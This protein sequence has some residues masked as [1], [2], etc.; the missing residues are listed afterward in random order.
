M[1]RKE[2]ETAV[3]AYFRRH[4][5]K[6]KLL[7]CPPEST[8]RGWASFRVIPRPKGN[9]RAADWPTETPTE[10][11]AAIYLQ[12]RGWSIS[13]LVWA[14]RPMAL[15]IERGESLTAKLDLIHKYDSPQDYADSFAWLVA[16]LK[17]F[18]DCSVERPATIRE[19]YNRATRTWQYFVEQP[20]KAPAGEHPVF[21]DRVLKGTETGAVHVN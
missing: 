9:T 8:V 17:V 4:G 10:L 5:I 7:R 1:T 18:T 11:A 15:A 13:R 21:C 12:A 3:N 20:A 6:G 2:V 19:H 14:R 16:A